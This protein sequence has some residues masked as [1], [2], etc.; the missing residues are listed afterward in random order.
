MPPPHPKG[1]QQNLGCRVTENYCACFVGNL[2]LLGACHIFETYVGLLQDYCSQG[3]VAE[4][5]VRFL[6]PN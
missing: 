2:G 1:A 4:T 6:K 3:K 5:S